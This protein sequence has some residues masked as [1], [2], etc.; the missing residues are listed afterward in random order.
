MKKFQRFIRKIGF[1]TTE[2]IK[3]INMSKKNKVF[4]VF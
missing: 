1:G 2:E 3:F 4:E